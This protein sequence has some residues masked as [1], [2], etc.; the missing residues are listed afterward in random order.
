MFKSSRRVSLK[1][2]WYNRNEN[3]DL[4]NISFNNDFWL[5]ISYK[6]KMLIKFLMKINSM[7]YSFRNIYQNLYCMTHTQ[8]CLRQNSLEGVKS[9]IF[10]FDKYLHAKVI[11]NFDT[12]TSWKPTEDHYLLIIIGR[13]YIISSCVCPESICNVKNRR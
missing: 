11:K 12:I 3:V 13:Y 5:N 2:V 1:L 8:I 6:R 7:L 4:T 10:V 9:R